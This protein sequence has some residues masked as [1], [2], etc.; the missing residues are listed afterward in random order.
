MWLIQEVYQAVEQINPRLS[1]L[2]SP[3]KR[4]EED[5]PPLTQLQKQQ[6]E[7]MGKAKE[8]QSTLE[9]LVAL[10]Q[11][12]KSVNL[13]DMFDLL[14]QSL[15]FFSKY[16]SLFLY[17]HQLK[18]NLLCSIFIFIH[19]VSVDIPAVDCS[20]FCVV[21]FLGVDLFSSPTGTFMRDYSEHWWPQ[22]DMI[23]LL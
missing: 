20:L 16:C 5:H 3:L 1:A 11:R 7:F 2:S 21:V 8:K 10:W 9:S 6:Q 17:S 19:P 14:T 22:E 13:S 12:Y 4:R 18:M 15:L 23:T